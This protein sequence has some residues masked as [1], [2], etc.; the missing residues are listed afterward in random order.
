MTKEE[1]NKLIELF[2]KANEEGIITIYDKNEDYYYIDHVFEDS[3]QFL[4]KIKSE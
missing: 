3:G 4:I 2:K 1:L